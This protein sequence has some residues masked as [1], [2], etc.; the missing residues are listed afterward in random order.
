M[1]LNICPT[2][3]YHEYITLNKQAHTPMSSK[4]LMV[5]ITA[6]NHTVV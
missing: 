3:A 5:D 4:C 6:P 1:F 2:V